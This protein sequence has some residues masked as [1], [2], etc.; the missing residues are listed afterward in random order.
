MALHGVWSDNFRFVD[1][2]AAGLTFIF[3]HTH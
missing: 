3:Q 2:G 1:T